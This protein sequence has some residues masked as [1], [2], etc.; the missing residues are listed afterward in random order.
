MNLIVGVRKID[1]EGVDY[2]TVFQSKIRV[3][4]RLSANVLFPARSARIFGA[5]YQSIMPRIQRTSVRLL[6]EQKQ[7]Y[8][9][10]S[11]SSLIVACAM[12]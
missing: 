11:V 2:S 1:H 5:Y 8:H 6:L 4:Y 3:S 9:V 12:R 7:G 10:G